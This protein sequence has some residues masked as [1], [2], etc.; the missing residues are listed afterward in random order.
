MYCGTPIFRPTIV[1][2]LYMFKDSRSA[3]IAVVG[4]DGAIGLSLL[5]GAETTTN[6]ATAQSAGFAYQLAGERL[7]EEFER[8]RPDA[9]A[10][11]DEPG[12]AHG[13]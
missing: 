11:A 9:Q 1:S 2:L 6:R 10:T 7:K 13:F 8:R 12:S 5:T 3:E 4:N